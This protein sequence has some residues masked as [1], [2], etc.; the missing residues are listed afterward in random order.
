MGS[1][2]PAEVTGALI[3]AMSAALVVLLA[4]ILPRREAD[5]ADVW[6]LTAML[7]LVGAM[8]GFYLRTGGG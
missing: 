7:T 6:G 4:Y 8:V 5:P 2:P 1:C 3:G